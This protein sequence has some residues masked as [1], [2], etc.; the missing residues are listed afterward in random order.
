MFSLLSVILSTGGGVVGMPGP[1][2]LPGEGVY[3]G[4]GIMEGVG[5]P[6]DGYTT[7]RYTRYI[8]QY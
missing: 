8:P 2:S 1:R 3:Q 5:I 7:G 4:V 6:G